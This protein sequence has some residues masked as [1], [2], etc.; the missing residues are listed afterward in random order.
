MQSNT[1]QFTSI[2]ET[3][4]KDGLTIICSK[5]GGDVYKHSHS[6]WL[7]TVASNPEAIIFKFVPISSLLT[8][9]PG[10]GYLSHAINLYLRYKPSPEDLQYFLEFQIPR[11]WA[12]MFCE[13]P[14]RHQRRKTSSLSLQFCCFGPK[15]HISST[16]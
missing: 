16:Q 6:N 13:L 7:Q 4:S 2:S 11:Q 3:S 1:T 5:R 14:L 12:P 8:G 15:L 9:I 10:S